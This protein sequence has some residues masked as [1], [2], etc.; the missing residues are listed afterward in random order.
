LLDTEGESEQGVLSGL[1]FLGD[2][3]LE[4]SLGGSDH[5][6]G[7]VSLGSTS[8]HVLDEISV[9]GGIDDGEVIFGGLELPKGDINGNTSLPLTLELVHNPGVFEG[10]LSHISGFLLILLNG[11]L[12]DTT[13]LVDKVAS[14]GGLSRVDVTDNEQVDVY[15]ILL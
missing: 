11:S 14:G 6:D 7:A 9:S 2:T 15:F 4:L 12:V 10:G 1:S 3:S 8:D 5:K 13:A